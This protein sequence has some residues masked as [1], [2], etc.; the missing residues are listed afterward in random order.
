[1]KDTQPAT[2]MMPILL[3]ALVYP[4]AGQLAQRRFFAALFYAIP[5]TASLV[6]L[7][8]TLYRTFRD[9]Y[10]FAFDLNATPTEISLAGKLL[11]PMTI[12]A[13][14]Y[15]ANVIDATVANIRLSAAARAALIPPPLPPTGR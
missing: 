12:V 9:L 1:M 4:G 2:G 13:V 6:P 3:S 14:I 5:F 10:R 11:V 15:T 7:A 8:I